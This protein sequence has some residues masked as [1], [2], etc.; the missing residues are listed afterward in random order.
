MRGLIQLVSHANVAIN[1]QIVGKIAHGIVALI[2]IEKS[3]TIIQAEKLIN[4]I[5]T[6][7]IF[8]DEACKMNLSLQD[9]RGGLLLI[10]QFTLV[11]ETN[12]G[13]RPGFSTGMPPEQGKLLFNELVAYAKQIYPLVETGQFGA[14]MQINL[15][16][17][18]PVTFLLE[19]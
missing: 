15:C 8:P 14:H 19:T 6:Y 16:N 12:K 11:A 4:R 7:R 13:T 1:S 5:L 17:D 9:V 10:P 18:G 3:D 2:G